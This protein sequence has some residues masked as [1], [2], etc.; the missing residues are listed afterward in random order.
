MTFDETL[1]FL[2]EQVGRSVEVSVALPLPRRDEP[3]HLAGFS[4]EVESVRQ[5]HARVLPE[6][7]FVWFTHDDASPAPGSLR[8]DRELFED[9]DVHA[10]PVSE[11]EERNEFGMTWTLAI[12][13]GGVLTSVEVFV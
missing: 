12:R 4:G 3:T 13:Q 8:I 6:A 2:T 10:N 5:S 9:A 7:W 1:Q 11:P